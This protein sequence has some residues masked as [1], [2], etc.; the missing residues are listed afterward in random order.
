MGHSPP[1][2]T[3]ESLPIGASFA[4]F[5][6]QDMFLVIV[7]HDD[8]ELSIEDPNYFPTFTPIRFAA[9]RPTLL[10]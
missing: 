5:H 4:R 7:T 8:Y 2:L 1:H 9:F 3:L 6:R 10:C